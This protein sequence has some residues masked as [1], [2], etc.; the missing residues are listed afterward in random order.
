MAVRLL[1]SGVSLIVCDRNPEVVAPLRER[2][3]SVADS[4]RAV[5]DAAEIV[6]ASM[7]LAAASMEVALGAEGGAHDSPDAMKR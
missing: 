4:P 1:E 5:A 2:G 3:A 6:F 7:P